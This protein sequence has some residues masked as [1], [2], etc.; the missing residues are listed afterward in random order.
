[1]TPKSVAARAVAA[2]TPL[3]SRTPSSAS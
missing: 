1:M 2:R 3:T